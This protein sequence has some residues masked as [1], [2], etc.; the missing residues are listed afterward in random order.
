MSCSKSKLVQQCMDLAEVIRDLKSCSGQE[1]FDPGQLKQMTPKLVSVVAAMRGESNTLPVHCG[2]IVEACEALKQC[3]VKFLQQLKS[4]S[5]TPNEVS[6]G[7]IEIA[8]KLKDVADKIKELPDNPSPSLPISPPGSPS[9]PKN[10]PYIPHTQPM[11]MPVAPHTLHKVMTKTQTPPS[12]VSKSFL[13][14]S[15]SN[16]SPPSS[17]SRSFMDFPIPVRQIMNQRE[18]VKSTLTALVQAHKEL[19]SALCKEVEEKLVAQINN[20]LSP[21][22]TA[23]CDMVIFLSRC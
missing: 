4:P 13:T 3:A 20:I 14:S 11:P 17:P 22:K 18:E 15:G 21:G 8:V 10:K 19:N 5:S 1:C 7:I 12:P 16:S 6:A 9:L 2:H 23:G